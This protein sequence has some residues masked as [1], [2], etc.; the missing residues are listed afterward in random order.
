[1]KSPK[2]V[3]LVTR[4]H[5][6]KVHL[7]KT[8]D[9]V[10]MLRTKNLLELFD[11]LLKSDYA[12]ELSR[13]STKELD[14]YQLERT[15]YQKLSERF[16]FLFEVTSGRVRESLEEYFK[17]IEIENVKRII[18]AIHGKEGLG[19]DQLVPIPRRFQTVNSSAL[20]E[21]HTMRQ[22]V[23]LLR[24]TPYGRLRNTVDMYEQTGNPTLFEAQ[25][26]NI[27]YSGFWETLERVS[28]NSKV[29]KLVGTEADLKNLFYV[30]SLKFTNTEP[31][32]TRKSLVNI[33][34]RLSKTLTQQ[35]IDSPMETAP[36][37]FTGPPYA[38]LAKEAG[39]LLEKKSPVEAEIAFSRFLYSYAETSSL[40]NP[41]DLVYVFAYLQ[42]CFKEA[43]N[44]TTLALGKQL[45]LEE[46]RIQSLLFL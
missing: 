18:R 3:Y 17:Q 26:D 40:R 39:E 20:L 25:L 44:L 37:L 27:F 11:L 12:S 35:L 30:L 10:R 31:E 5:G 29:K 34:Y 22:M 19:Q 21:T 33:H 32:I 16:T 9:Y 4:A 23:D 14:A 45:G 13:V 8:D 7:F 28:G 36:R 2:I 42:L 41:N 24:E 1:M 6:L 38:D 43:K 46:E 15:F